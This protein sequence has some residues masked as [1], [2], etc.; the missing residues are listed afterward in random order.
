M[1]KG[2]I[3]LGTMLTIG[4]MVAGSVAAVFGMTNSVSKDLNEATLSLGQQINAVS[5]REVK[6]ETLIPTIEKRLE[7]MEQTM[8]RIETAIGKIGS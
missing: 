4:A 3:G 5:E 2:Q 1:S 7:N 8:K 6:L